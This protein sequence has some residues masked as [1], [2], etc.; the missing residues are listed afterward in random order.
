MSQE[1]WSYCSKKALELLIW[2]EKALEHGMILVDTKYE[3]AAMR[4]E[5]Y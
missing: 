2:P 5:N 3:M 4:R 1:D